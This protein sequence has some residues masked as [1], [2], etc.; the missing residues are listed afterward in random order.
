ML[1]NKEL[2]VENIRS[3]MLKNAAR[4]WGVESEDI[5]ATFDPLVT[6]MIEACAYELGK[7]NNEIHDSQSR[8][9][10]QLAQVLSPDVFTGPR[11]AYAVAHAR[12]SEPES[13]L[14]SEM[15]FYAQQKII[16]QDQKEI[17]RDIYFSPLSDCTVFDADI[18]YIATGRSLFEFK[19]PTFRQMMEGSATNPL[20]PFHLWL[21]IDVAEKLKSV[22]R[23][24]F[25]FDWRNDPE[26]NTYLNLLPLVKWYLDDRELTAAKG[27]NTN[28]NDNEDIQSI[29]SHYDISWRTEQALKNIFHGN[30]YTLQDSAELDM[31]KIL[32]KYPQEFEDIFPEKMLGKIESNLLWIKL[33]FPRAFPLNALND[34]YISMNA[35]PVL[36]RRVNKL[37]YQ[38]KSNLNIVP[39]KCE[40]TF[41]DLID[42][43]NSEGNYFQSNP[44]ESGFKNEA[45]FYTLRSGGV[46]RFDKRSATE[47]LQIVTDLLRDESASFSSLG[48]EFLN[49]YISQIN[50]S[51]AMIENRLNTKGESTK[52]S[53]FIIINPLRHNEI[54]FIKFWSTS[55]IDANL[56]KAGAK[57]N[58][59]SGSEIRSNSLMLLT[60]AFGGKKPLNETERISAFRRSILTHDRVVTYEDIVSFCQAELGNLAGKINVEKGWELSQHP[61]TGYVRNLEAHIVPRSAQR[62]SEEEWNALSN[63]LEIKINDKSNKLIP[64]RIRIQSQN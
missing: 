10:E 46:E 53:H 13:F 22:D 25:Y 43:Q 19:N 52:P 51:L 57:L 11:P 18:R 56:V 31:K 32:K 24:A 38:L 41:Y 6:M 4:I 27:I 35:F 48:N 61:Q 40:E 14:G 34:V 62:I 8:V 45:G 60:S 47:F 16:T 36:N 44:L 26:K 30:F 42:I 49:S 59:A 20:E 3:R 33:V 63:E 17:S 39:L 23:F 37:T 64:I 7:I 21:G 58:M 54:V 50:Q 29:E 1:N 5:E 12:A 55:A 9:L 28:K 15:Q 2:S